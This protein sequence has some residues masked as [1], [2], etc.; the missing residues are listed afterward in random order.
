MVLMQGISADGSVAGA[1]GR[2]RDVCGL[3]SGRVEDRVDAGGP[4]RLGVAAGGQ[5]VEALQLGDLRDRDL[6][7]VE[8]GVG[9]GGVLA[10]VDDDL[11]H[12]LEGPVDQQ[13]PLLQ[14]V[15]ATEA[16]RR[17]LAE[18]VGAGRGDDR[19]GGVVA[20]QRLDEPGQVERRRQ[21]GPLSGLHLHAL[22][23][24]LPGR[25]LRDL[26]GDERAVAPQSQQEHDELVSVS[27]H[28]TNAAPSFENLVSHRY[29]P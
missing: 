19:L 7:L 18:R 9:L 8:H 12:V 3:G 14:L 23:G 2:L 5:N 11:E 29:T 6:V 10:L 15:L 22:R 21:E 13:R 28:C 4:L 26:G 25:V 17:G 16:V 20:Q 1:G 27:Q 24:E